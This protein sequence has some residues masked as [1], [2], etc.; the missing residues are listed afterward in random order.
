SGSAPNAPRPAARGNAPP[1][2]LQTALRGSRH[3]RQ[4]GTILFRID[5]DAPRPDQPAQPQELLLLLLVGETPTWGIQQESL[6][7]SLNI[8]WTLD[9][10][11][12]SRDTD[13]EPV[14]RIL[15]P[16]FSGT[17]DSM[18]RVIHTWA[19]N[20]PDRK[21]ARFWV[22]SGAATAVE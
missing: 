21:A 2:A 7:T 15:G 17:V 9:I 5:R 1:A 20:R 13:R 8:A 12:N 18:A 4:P 22:C 10:Q 19:V 16:T 6:M 3:E 14:M 11:R